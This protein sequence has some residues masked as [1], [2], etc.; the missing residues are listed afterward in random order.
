MISNIY[1][2]DNKQSSTSTIDIANVPIQKLTLTSPSLSLNASGVIF[3]GTAGEYLTFGD[4]VYLK[5][6]GKYWKAKGDVYSTAAVVGMAAATIG[7]NT[8]GNFLQLG[9]ARNDSWNWTIGD[10]LYL[11]V[12]TGGTM[13]QTAPTADTNQLVYIGYALTATSINFNPTPIII[14][15]TTA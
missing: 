2:C 9:I 10:K 11:S 13:T 14:E 6:D 7:I 3:T 8:S 1:P 15:I 5:S 12:T 4:I